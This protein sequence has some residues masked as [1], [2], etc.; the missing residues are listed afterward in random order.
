SG[1]G[2][3]RF[4][5]ERWSAFREDVAFFREALGPQYT[6]VLADHGFNPTPLWAAIGGSLANLVPA[7]SHAGVF[8][9][10]LLDPLLLAAAFAAVAWTFGLRVALLSI[11]PFSIVYTNTLGMMGCGHIY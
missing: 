9:L 10:T 11:F 3:D 5:S 2:R 4:T 8:L 7:G 6:A 1:P